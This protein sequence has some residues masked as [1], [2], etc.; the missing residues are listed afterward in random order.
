[1]GICTNKKKPSISENQSQNYDFCLKKGVYEKINEAGNDEHPSIPEKI[2]DILGNSIA[3][4]NFKINRK[5]GTGFF[6][7]INLNKKNFI[8]LSVV[9]M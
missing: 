9:I 2:I 3:K 1:M 8:F 4:I 6:M 5:S 7:Q